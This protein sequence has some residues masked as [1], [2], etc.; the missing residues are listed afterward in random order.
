[1]RYS[2]VNIIPVFLHVDDD[3]VVA[4]VVVDVDVL[5]KKVVVV[6]FVLS[7]VAFNSPVDNIMTY[8]FVIKFVS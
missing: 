1:M 3:V 2:L 6:V 8:I 4:V 7:V 5:L